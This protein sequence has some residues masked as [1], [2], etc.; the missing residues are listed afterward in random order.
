MRY[1]YCGN[2]GRKSGYKRQFGWGTFFMVILTCG[3]S[4]TEKSI[5]E[6]KSWMLLG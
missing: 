2:H 6:A 1:L 4:L 3:F 5:K